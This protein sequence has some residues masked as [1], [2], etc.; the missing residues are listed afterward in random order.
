MRTH[1][2]GYYNRATP[3]AILRAPSSYSSWT[4][5]FIYKSGKMRF[6]ILGEFDAGR[7][8]CI[9]ASTRR[10]TVTMSRGGSRKRQC[11]VVGERKVRKLCGNHGPPVP[12]TSACNNLVPKTENRCLKTNI[13]AELCILN[14]N[15]HGPVPDFYDI[16]NTTHL[17]VLL[18]QL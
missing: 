2:F 16:F 8:R 7:L 6:G 14:S 3:K 17:H 1:S 15:A 13:P 10:L 11:L 4:R 9:A 5:A 12:Y 18:R